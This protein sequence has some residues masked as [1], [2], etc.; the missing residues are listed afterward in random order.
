MIQ[1]L[2]KAHWKI[3]RKYMDTKLRIKS[4]KTWLQQ[5]PPS[6]NSNSSQFSG[7]TKQHRPSNHL[8]N[9]HPSN[10]LH[11]NRPLNNHLSNQEEDRLEVEEDRLEVEDRHQEE[12][13][14]KYSQYLPNSHSS[15]NN[16]EV[17]GDY[18]ERN[19]TCT[20]ETGRRHATGIINGTSTCTQIWT[21]KP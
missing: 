16:M 15:S 19:Q 17:M 6:L 12:D 21:K 13:L 8:L 18:R 1:T 3:Q 2:N 14:N 11:D 10:H 4:T 20:P 9:H 5:Q 7:R